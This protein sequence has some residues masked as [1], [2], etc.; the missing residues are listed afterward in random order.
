MCRPIN[1]LA[2]RTPA[3]ANDHTVHFGI[4]RAQAGAR[5]KDRIG[6]WPSHD[7]V[8]GKRLG[9]FQIVD[10]IDH[11]VA[12]CKA[13][14]FHDGQNLLEHLFLSACRADNLN[15]TLLGRCSQQA[16]IQFIGDKSRH[17]GHTA[18]F[19]KIL[20]IAQVKEQFAMRFQLFKIGVRLFKRYIRII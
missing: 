11:K 13:S 2:C 9:T 16:D 20:V 12:A 5:Q 18:R 14:F 6:S 3:K 1:L 10:V 8:I 7:D 17:L 15:F 4:V 19:G